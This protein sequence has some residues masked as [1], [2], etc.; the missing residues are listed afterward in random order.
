MVGLIEAFSLPKAGFVTISTSL[1]G[2]GGFVGSL[3]LYRFL[4]IKSII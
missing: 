3:N 4:F 1:E 2:W